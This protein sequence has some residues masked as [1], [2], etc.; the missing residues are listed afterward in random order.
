MSSELLRNWRLCHRLSNIADL[1]HSCQLPGPGHAFSPSPTSPLGAEPDPAPRLRPRG[2]SS[3]GPQVAL[4]RTVALGLA[5]ALGRTAALG[6]TSGLR[7][8]VALGKTVGLGQTITMGRT[9]AL[10]RT[11][12]LGKTV[13]LGRTTV[14]AVI[15]VGADCR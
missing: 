6:Q 9:I 5:V 4:G 8:T 10:G 14:M 13:A 11:V 2:A 15:F 1:S 12:A 7:Q 3:T